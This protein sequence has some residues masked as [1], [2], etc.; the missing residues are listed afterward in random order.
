MGG[1]AAQVV[2]GKKNTPGGS[3]NHLQSAILKNPRGQESLD[4]GVKFWAKMG[5]KCSFLTE[6]PEYFQNDGELAQTGWGELFDP[7]L[8]LFHLLGLES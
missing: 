7:S 3:S 6:N 5:R 8:T 2:S 4:F 1:N